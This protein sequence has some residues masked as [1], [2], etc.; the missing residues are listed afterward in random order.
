MNKY[1]VELDGISVVTSIDNIE[2]GDLTLLFSN[3]DAEDYSYY[4][5]GSMNGK[6]LSLKL[7]KYMGDT[8]EKT[9]F[10]YVLGD[11]EVYFETR[12]SKNQIVEVFGVMYQIKDIDKS[13]KELVVDKLDCKDAM[14]LYGVYES[15]QGLTIHDREKDGYAADRY[16]TERFDAIGY[17]MQERIKGRNVSL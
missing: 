14:A 9:K 7:V 4:K 12:P 5:V 2:K 3:N 1:F 11:K 10:E 15:Q 8:S 17:V 13:T 6:L 16:F